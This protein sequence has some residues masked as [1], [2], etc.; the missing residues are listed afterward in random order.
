MCGSGTPV[1]SGHAALT[2]LWGLIKMGTVKTDLD[3]LGN[4]ISHFLLSFRVCILYLPISLLDLFRQ[5]F[6]FKSCIAF[7]CT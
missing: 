1:L 3:E 6:C 5:I 4:I 7:R 2:I